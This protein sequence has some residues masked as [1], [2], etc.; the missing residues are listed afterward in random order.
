MTKADFGLMVVRPIIVAA[1]IC[2]YP[3]GHAAT[4]QNLPHYVLAV[5]LLTI[6]MALMFLAS[7]RGD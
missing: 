7:K 2:A 3:D 1:L 4:W 5:L 6:P